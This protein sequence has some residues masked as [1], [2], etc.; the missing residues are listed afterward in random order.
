MIGLRL[1]R[2]ASGADR[3]RGAHGAGR[4]SVGSWMGSDVD[5]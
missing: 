4:E 5:D 3:K 2:P 1:D